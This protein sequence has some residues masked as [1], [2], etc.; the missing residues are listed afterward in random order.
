[1][2][3]CVLAVALS[4]LALLGQASSA[5]AQTADELV[6]KNIQAKGGM[7]KLRA[8]QSIKQVGRV[9]I[10]GIE[11]KQTLYAK[12]PNM[13][14]QEI[15]LKGQVVVMA[16]GGKTPWML[17]PLLGSVAPIAMSGPPADMIRDQ[18][19][20]DGPLVDYKNK[21][22]VLEL[23]GLETLGERKVHHLKLTDKNRQ[24]QHVYLDA[25]T[26]L[27]TKLT[28]QNELGQTFE[29]E[30]SDFRDVEGIKIPFSIRTLANGIQQGQITVESV[31]FN[32]KIDDGIFKMPR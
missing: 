4:A 13:L 12:R 17:N 15:D 10:Q 11:G 32:V 20:F 24:L 30:L 9:N 7:D 3:R 8:V 31:E 18:S 19:S 23:V 16:F 21:G 27:E 22:S 28:S 25:E 2:H 29:Q 14:R 1:M 6:A 26:F 5:L